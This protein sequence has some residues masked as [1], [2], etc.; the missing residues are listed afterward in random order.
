M[1]TSAIGT[2]PRRTVGTAWNT[3]SCPVDSRILVTVSS[4]GRRRPL[5][6]PASVGWEVPACRASSTWLRPARCRASR[7][8][9][10]T[11]MK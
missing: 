4:R 11:D 10:L 3:S 8:I 1:L 5:S 9:A 7:I 6:Y 2:A